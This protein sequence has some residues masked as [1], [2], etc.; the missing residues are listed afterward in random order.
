MAKGIVDVN[1]LSEMEYNYV[2]LVLGCG[3]GLPNDLHLITDT[4]GLMLKRG[5][6]IS[7]ITLVQEKGDECSFNYMEMSP[8]IAQKFALK[9]GDRV[10]LDYKA[11][12]KTLQMQRLNSSSASGLLLLDP[13]KN[14]DGV[15]TIG[16]A[17]LS[18]L[19]IPEDAAGTMIT[20]NNGS[21]SRRLRV[22]IPENELDETL[23]MSASNLKA[24][25]LT[26]RKKWKFAYNQ[27]TKVLSVVTN[28]SVEAGISKNVKR[29]AKPVRKSQTPVLNH[30]NKPKRE[31]TKPQDH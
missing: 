23:R 7:E 22:V 13:R 26:P 19:G 9:H 6:V 11:D 16:Y 27:T 18:W 4:E 5:N 1:V 10:V 20:V 29:A 3:G 15:I 2:N 12:T 28:K 25:G 21:I 8:E 14:R 24:M 17:L 31:N 30:K